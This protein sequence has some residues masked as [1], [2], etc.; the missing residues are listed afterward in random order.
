MSFNVA[1]W[2]GGIVALSRSFFSRCSVY[3]LGG[4]SCAGPRQCRV[5]MAFAGVK[6]PTFCEQQ[7][8]VVYG[9]T[10]AIPYP[11]LPLA[12]EESVWR[13]TVVLDGE[14]SVSACVRRSMVDTAYKR[15]FA[16]I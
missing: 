16:S 4:R 8:L 9:V 13:T 2:S 6:V 12:V 5:D 14:M 15:D 7:L 10:A 3:A 1:S 11:T